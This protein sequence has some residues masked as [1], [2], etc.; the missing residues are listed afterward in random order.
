[1][2]HRNL[3]ERDIHTFKEYF[4]YL[5]AACDP[6]FYKHLWYWLISQANI[7]LNLLRKAHLHPHYHTIMQFGKAL[8][9]MKRL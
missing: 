2:Y 1:M 5:L 6:N 9:T 3:A 8:I 4:K 7:I